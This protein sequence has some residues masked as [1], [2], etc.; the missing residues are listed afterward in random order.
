M[1]VDSGVPHSSYFNYIYE[2]RNKI[3]LMH[4]DFTAIDAET[5]EDLKKYYMI[6]YD[7]MFGDQWF[8]NT[9]EK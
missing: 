1:I 2:L 4:R 8:Y 5:N 3:P 9:R 6:Q 7:L